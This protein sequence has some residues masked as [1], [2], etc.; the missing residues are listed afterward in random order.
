[1]CVCGLS[2]HHGKCG[3]S[4]P[5]WWRSKFVETAVYACCRV[6]VSVGERAERERVS[7]L[8]ECGCIALEC[9][10]MFIHTHLH[11]HT[12]LCVHSSLW[13]TTQ[14]PEARLLESAEFDEETLCTWTVV[15]CS[16]SEWKSLESGVGTFPQWELIYFTWQGRAH[17]G[18]GECR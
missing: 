11:T 12:H 16:S 10:V 9:T 5:P 18:P 14:S 1:M 15:W 17:Q 7:E 3:L 6:C 13:L 4:S 2:E 8:Y